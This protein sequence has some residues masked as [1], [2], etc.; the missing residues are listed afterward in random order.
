M[1][2]TA[3]TAPKPAIATGLLPR[4]AATVPAAASTRLATATAR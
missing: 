1:P 3:M 4:S 2:I